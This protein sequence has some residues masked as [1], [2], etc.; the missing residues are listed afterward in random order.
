MKCERCGSELNAEGRCPMC[1]TEAETKNKVRVLTPS[2]KMNYDGVTIEAP[3]DGSEGRERVE[4]DIRFERRQSSGPKIYYKSFGGGNSLA[5]KLWLAL[6]A[7]CI[8]G[9]IFFVALPVAVI[10][11][12]I[13]IGIWLFYS[14]FGI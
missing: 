9:F 12:V 2:E 1:D 11:L 14:F 8:L 5:R 7:I 3:S 13:G 10:A 6:I 4:Q